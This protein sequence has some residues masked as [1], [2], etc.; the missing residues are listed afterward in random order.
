MGILL[1]YAFT[2]PWLTALCSCLFAWAILKARNLFIT[3]SAHAHTFNGI[4]KVLKFF[5]PL[6]FLFSLDT[7]ITRFSRLFCCWHNFRAPWSPKSLKVLLVAGSTLSKP[8]RFLPW[9]VLLKSSLSLDDQFVYFH[10]QENSLVWNAFVVFPSA[11]CCLPVVLI[12]SILWTF[13]PAS[14]C[15][16]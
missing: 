16:F 14:N 8:Q 9:P 1:I 12:L 13:L 5:P 15:T 7:Q 3:T 4:P 10:F 6:C 11:S 2:I